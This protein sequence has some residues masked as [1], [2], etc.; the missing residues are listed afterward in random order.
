MIAGYLNTLFAFALVYLS[1]LDLPMLK[2]HPWLLIAAGLVVVA[3]ALWSRGSDAMKW[4]STVIILFG[5]MLAGFGVWHLLAPFADLFVFWFVFWTGALV[6]VVA[7]W[8][9]LYRPR[10]RP[11]IA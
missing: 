3:L 4:F 10:A 9:A 2:A 6:G 7:L 1:I 11:A 8:A 5:A